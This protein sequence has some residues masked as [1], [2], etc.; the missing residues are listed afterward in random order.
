[1]RVDLRPKRVRLRRI[2]EGREEGLENELKDIVVQSSLLR[3]QRQRKIQFK[4]H[5][6]LYRR[7][8]IVG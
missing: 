3:V 2:V 4:L 8:T 1:M 5:Q 6:Q 7:S